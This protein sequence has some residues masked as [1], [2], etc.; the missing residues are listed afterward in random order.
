MEKRYIRLNGD[1]RQSLESG[2]RSGK[3]PAFR[4]RC[5]Y[6]LLSDRGYDAVQ[7]AEVFGTTRQAV[8][9]W[10]TRFEKEGI[11][12]LRTRARKGA[13]PKLEI[14]NERTVQTVRNLIESE[15]RNLNAVVARVEQELGVKL[16]RRTLNR[17]LKNLITDGNDSAT[18]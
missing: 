1:Q 8:Y 13:P 9:R 3:G 6:V 16:S 17:F 11:D 10:F 4:Q 12:G 15:P 18:V 5:R 2:Y 14:T 7:I